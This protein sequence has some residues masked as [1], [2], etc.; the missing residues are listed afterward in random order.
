MTCFKHWTLSIFTSLM[1]VS[2]A[3]A[4]SCDIEPSKPTADAIIAYQACI[5]AGHQMVT[6]LRNELGTRSFQTGS[7]KTAVVHFS[8][9]IDQQDR[10]GRAHF[11]RALAYLELGKERHALKD[12]EAANQILPGYSPAHFY[13]GVTLHKLRRY[14]QAIDAFG[15]ALNLSA[16]G[17]ALAPIYFEKAQAEIKRKY[18]QE[19]R[20][21]LDNALES[22]PSYSKALF[23]RALLHKKSGADELAI[24]DYNQYILS[25]PESAEAHYNRGLIFQDLRRD[26]LAIQDFNRAIELNPRYV[27][28]RAS[29]GITYFWPVFP[30]LLVL[31]LG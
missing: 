9:I 20:K 31:L 6:D 25:N 15:V 14:Q 12:L 10:P 21:S 27:K 1:L 4:S 8:E 7:F 24:A 5:D 22:D 28:A 29:K 13:R 2:G 17:A 3:Q 30:V 16:G 18:I 26:H 11:N 23:A 19:A